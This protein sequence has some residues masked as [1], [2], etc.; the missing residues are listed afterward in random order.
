MIGKRHVS[1]TSAMSIYSEPDESFNHGLTI[2]GDIYFS[3]DY[4][5]KRGD[6]RI[7]MKQARQITPANAKSCLSDTY[8]K[9][10]LLPDRTKASK[11]KTSLRK[12][13][14]NPV[15]NEELVYHFPRCD[16]AYRTL[17]VSLW[18]QRAIGANLFLGEVLLPLAEFQFSATPEWYTLQDRQVH[19]HADGE[20]PLTKGSLTVGLKYQPQVL[21]GKIQDLGD[22]YVNIREAKDLDVSSPSNA[23]SKLN[24]YAKIR[25]LKILFFGCL[26]YSYLLPHKTKESKKKTKA[27]KKT[28]NPTWDTSFVYPN[29]EKTQLPSIG[30]EIAIYD[31]VRMAANEFLGG[32]RINA[33]MRNGRGMDASGPERDLWVSMMSKLNTNVQSTI[34]LRATLV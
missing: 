21:N 22:L 6:I 31:H 16:L 19:L 2:V 28:A 27:M 5:T 26:I 9:T 25:E 14:L 20:I 23:K 29:I 24:P 11:R 8:V 17:Q 33:G 12:N 1:V 3:V 10:Y 34:P 4:D 7:F 13:T 15:F 18:H 32:C 30:I